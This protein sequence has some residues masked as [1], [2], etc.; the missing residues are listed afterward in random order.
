VSAIPTLPG[1]P[2]IAEWPP[3]LDDLGVLTAVTSGIIVHNQTETAEIIAGLRH[4]L[5]VRAK[6]AVAL[7]LLLR[8]KQDTPLRALL[9]TAMDLLEPETD[10]TCENVV[11]MLRS[12]WSYGVGEL[13]ATSR[14]L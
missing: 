13:L 4:E 14:T 1:A 9:G 12:G 5:S 11:G 7:A 2:S 3:P 10:E 6:A 8:E